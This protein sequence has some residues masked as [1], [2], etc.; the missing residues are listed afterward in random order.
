MFLIFYYYFWLKGLSE[1][2]VSMMEARFGDLRLYLKE[3]KCFERQQ[4]KDMNFL[5]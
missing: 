3:T 5:N 4:Y 1:T 2:A